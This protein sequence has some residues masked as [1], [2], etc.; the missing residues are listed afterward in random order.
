MASALVP[1]DSTYVLCTKI[2]GFHQARKAS[3]SL[4]LPEIFFQGSVVI[5][6]E[7]GDSGS[8]TIDKRTGCG[9]TE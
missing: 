1:G 9:A 5:A 8:D 2:F 3:L 4:L 7:H 6:V